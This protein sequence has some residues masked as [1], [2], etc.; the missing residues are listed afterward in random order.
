MS[1][2]SQSRLTA[3]ASLLKRTRLSVL[4]ALNGDTCVGNY[5]VVVVPENVGRRLGTVLD[6]ARQIYGRTCGRANGE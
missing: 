3:R 6:G 1:I 5:L 4:I 2:T